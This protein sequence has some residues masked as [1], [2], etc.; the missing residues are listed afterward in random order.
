LQGVATLTDLSVSA[1]AD[2]GLP[3]DDGSTPI[4]LT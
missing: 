4:Q 1:V 2:P 3:V